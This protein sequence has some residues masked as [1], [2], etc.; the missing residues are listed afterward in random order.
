MEVIAYSSRPD[1]CPISFAVNLLIGPRETSTNSAL[2]FSV[3]FTIFEAMLN[4]KVNSLGFSVI[5]SGRA[6]FAIFNSH[7]MV[8]PWTLLLI[9]I[10]DVLGLGLGENFP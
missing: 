4:L 6:L 10:L 8:F 7:Q 9:K 5:L 1:L 3:S 2:S